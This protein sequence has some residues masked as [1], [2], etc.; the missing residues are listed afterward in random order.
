MTG[1]ITIQATFVITNNHETMIHQHIAHVHIQTTVL[2]QKSRCLALSENF[3]NKSWRK[4]SNIISP[5][6][7]N[8]GYA[9]DS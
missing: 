5:L 4:A 6:C 9:C 8:K 3:T 2:L 7:A 1:Y